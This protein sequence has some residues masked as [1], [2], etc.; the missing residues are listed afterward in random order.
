[1]WLSC[2]CTV[3]RK[4]LLVFTVS[5]LLLL[6]ADR[7]G[8]SG[9]YTH[10]SICPLFSVISISHPFD[11]C[12]RHDHFRNFCTNGRIE[13]CKYNFLTLPFNVTTA[14]RRAMVVIRNIDQFAYICRAGASAVTQSA[15]TRVTVKRELCYI[16]CIQTA[17]LTVCNHMYISQLNVL[18]DFCFR[19]FLSRHYR[20]R[21]T[22]ARNS[23]ASFDSP[24]QNYTWQLFAGFTVFCACVS[25]VESLV[26]IAYCRPM[27]SRTYY[28]DTNNCS[29]SASSS[30]T[31]APTAVGT[32]RKWN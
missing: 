28:H 12:I 26:I 32:P 22:L 18:I 24:S 16:S 30:Y 29:G 6:V 27:L 17:R 15:V 14:A 25:P 13:S 4:D 2:T 8:V 20:D 9:L 10:S 11:F 1:V 7:R 5:W 3:T 23:C 21:Q 31:A 19:R